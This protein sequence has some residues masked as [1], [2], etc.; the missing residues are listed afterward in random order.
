MTAHV[1]ALQ[2]KPI[3]PGTVHLVDLEGK[4]KVKHQDGHKEIVLLPQPS[5]DPE[6]PLNWVWRRKTWCAIWLMIAVFSADVSTTLLSPALLT[7]EKELG[8]PLATLN[9]GVGVQY[10]FF[11]WSNVLWQPLGLHFGRRPILLLGGLGLVLIG[12]WTSYVKSSGEW[13]I[14]RILLGSFYGPIETLIEVS[15]SDLYFAHQRGY[16]IGIYCWILFGV[17]FVGGTASGFVASNLGWKWIQFIASIIAAAALIGM[18]FCMEETMFYRGESHDETIGLDQSTVSDSSA[19]VSVNEKTA[20]DSAPTPET[21]SETG[22]AEPQATSDEA[23]EAP[24]VVMHRKTYIQRLKFWGARR[25]GQPNTLWRSI[26]MPFVLLR[27]PG[28][29]FSAIVVGSVLSWFN[30]VN[31]TIALVLTSEPYNF[32]S[33][34]VGVMFVAPAIGVSLGCAFAGVSADRFA[35]WMARRNG[36]FF[37][38]ES[39]LWLAAIPFVL[40]PAGCILFGVGAN[41]GVHWIGIAFGFGMICATFPIGSAIAINYIIDSYK[42]VSGDG[43]VSMIIVRN[44]MGFAFSYGVTPWIERC[45]VQNTYIALA[46]LGMFFWGLCFFF[47][48]F[49]KRFRES[50]AAAYWK[51]VE[52]HGLAAH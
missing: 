22:K 28:I 19:V 21:K 7:M 34:M 38:P 30:V 14:N 15:I 26:W 42:E 10:L 31:A 52:Q 16:W 29:V 17:P 40:H 23:S 41:H 3:I 32:S 13:Y 45:G 50:S 4:L 37:E 9:S 46:F 6:D 20:D 11:G 39:R 18:F 48:Y 8:I 24:G 51:L 1:Q 35:L 43:L 47:V 44:T 5:T 33:D 27:F 49:G 12:L 36:G 25:P 2:G